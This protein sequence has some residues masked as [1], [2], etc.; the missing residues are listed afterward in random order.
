MDPGTSANFCSRCGQVLDSGAKFCSLCGEAVRK[1]SAD[2]GSGYTELVERAINGDS[3]AF[4]DLYEKRFNDLYY[5]ALS[6]LRNPHDA[7]DATQMAFIQAW[8][9]IQKLQS[10]YAFKGWLTRIL[11]NNCIDLIRKKKPVLSEHDDDS[12]SFEDTLYEENIEFLPADIMDKKETQRLVREIVGDLPDAQRETIIL[13][14]FD[15]MPIFEIA[16]IMGVSEGTVKSRLYFGRLAVKE[17]VEEHEKQGVKLYSITGLPLL[18]SVLREG[19]LETALSA[20]AV[21][22]LWGAASASM[23]I[24]VAAGEVAAIAAGAAAGSAGVAGAAGTSGAAAGIIGK[25]AAAS[26]AAKIVAS[27]AACIIVAGGVTVGVLLSRPDIT[28]EVETSDA[29]HVNDTNRQH[30]EHDEFKLY[31]GADDNPS[32]SPHLSSQPELLEFDWREDLRESLFWWVSYLQSQAPLDGE[33][34]FYAVIFPPYE[35]NR[36]PMLALGQDPQRTLSELNQIYS[37]YPSDVLVIQRTP[38]GTSLLMPSEE[39]IDAFINS[40]TGDQ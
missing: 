14:Y 32:E 33:I 12:I 27:V 8:K 9:S 21:A 4:Q 7:E 10:P 5:I 25:I 39:E 6:M 37:D 34:S 3:A 31:E 24:G 20:E 30:L 28:T 29:N 19:A 35:T 22:G 40:Y 18:F 23:G 38:D 11:R 13:H 2:E 15:L 16:A 17:G 26:V 1:P 36:Y